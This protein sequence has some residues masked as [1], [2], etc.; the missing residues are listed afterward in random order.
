M[1]WYSIYTKPGREKFISERLSQLTD[2]EIL[3]PII[4]F[5]KF[6]RGRLALVDEELFPSY[7][8]AKLDIEKYFR[9]IKYTRGVKRFLGD[10]NGYPYVVDEAII[11]NI[12]ERMVDGYIRLDPPDLKKGDKDHI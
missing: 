7:I 2:I 12:K 8:F 4:K 5:K 10:S 6:R 3:N 1:H 9:T 11:K